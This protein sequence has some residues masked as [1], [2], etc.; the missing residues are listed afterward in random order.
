MSIFAHLIQQSQGHRPSQLRLLYATKATAPINADEILF[1]SRLVELAKRQSGIDVAL[2]LH[3]TGVSKDD[4]ANAKGLPEQTVVG[5]VSGEDLEAALGAEN[6]RSGT[7]C[8]VCGPPAMTDSMVEYL[9]GRK[10]MESR[11]VLCEKWW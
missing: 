8:Y 7:V 3:L 11:R 10:G 6:D 1:V 2:R 9:S 4:I 5:R